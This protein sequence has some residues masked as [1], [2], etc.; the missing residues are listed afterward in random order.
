MFKNN[1]MINLNTQYIN[2]CQTY[3]SFDTERLE[4]VDTNHA[5][6]SPVRQEQQIFFAIFWPNGI[7]LRVYQI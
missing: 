5:L 4:L 3:Y 1:E 7:K 2:I 6:P